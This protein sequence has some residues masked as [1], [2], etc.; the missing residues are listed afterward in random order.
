MNYY[1]TVTII[2]CILII[3]LV[4]SRRFKRLEEAKQKKL[5]LDAHKFF[6]IACHKVITPFGDEQSSQ[7]YFT[8]TIVG[9]YLFVF[10]AVKLPDE[11]TKYDIVLRVQF[12]GYTLLDIGASGSLSRRTPKV[13]SYSGFDNRLSKLV[14]D[15]LVHDACIQSFWTNVY[16]NNVP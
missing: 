1:L 6:V 4:L 15:S 13:L 8:F 16:K 2:A 14:G 7:E 5:V 9:V 3:S 10:K 11:A 12:T